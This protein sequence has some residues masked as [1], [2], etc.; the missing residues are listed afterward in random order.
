MLEHFHVPEEDAVRIMPDAL[1]KT[2]NELFLK[3]GM[4]KQ[5][6]WQATDVLLLSDTRGVDTERRLR[7]GSWNRRNP[8]DNGAGDRKGS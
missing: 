8:P 2:V 6:A 4:L 3:M 7:S 5:D 1:R